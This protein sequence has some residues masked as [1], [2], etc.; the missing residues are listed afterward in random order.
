MTRKALALTLLLATSAGAN[1]PVARGFQAPSDAPAMSHSRAATPS[2]AASSRTATAVAA[3]AAPVLDGRDDDAVWATAPVTTGFRQFQ[4]VE[5]GEARFRTEFRVT[6]DD[7][8]LYVFVRMFDPHPDSIMHALSRRDVRGPSD[9]IK[10]II[11]AYHDRRS[12]VE[13]AVNPDGVKR[14]YAIFDDNH[15]DDSWNGVWDVATRVDSLG[16][17]AEFRVPF[18]QLRYAAAPTQTF[19]FGVWRDI[20]RLNERDS[21]PVYS[22]THTGLA[23]QLGELGGIGDIGSARHVEIAPYVV[24]K[25]ASRLGGSGYERVQDQTVGADLRFGITPNLALNATVNP[26][27]GQV[28]ADPAVVNLGAFETFYSEKRP[29]FV[30]G[31]GLYRFELNCYIA[32]DCGNEGL[33]YSRRIGR[34]PHLLDT[35]GDAGSP[36]GTPIAA[37]AKLTGRSSSGL[38]VGV[39]DAVTQGV[40]GTGGRTIEPRT[41]YAVVRLRQDFRN[42]ESSIGLIG[43]AV[44]R[45]LDT[46]TEDFLRRDAYVAGA[47][48]R[49]RFGGGNYQVSAA[50]VGSRVSGSE[51]AIAATQTDNV[52]GYQRPD[53][54]GR[55]DPARTSLTGSSAELIFG[56][57]GGGLLRFETA[58][59]RQSVGFEPNDLGYL[60]RADQQDWNTWAALSFRQPKGIYKSL[61]INGN[62]WNAWTSDGLPLQRGVNVNAHMWLVNNWWVHAGTSVNRIGGTFCDRCSRGGPAVRQSVSV[63]PWFGVNGDGRRTVSPFL[64][65]NLDR[66]DGGRSSYASFEP[67]FDLRVSTQL[68]ASVGASV[69][70]NVDD[71]QWYGNFADDAGQT[72][73]AFAHLDQKTLGLTTRLSFAATPD[74]ALDFYAQPYTSTGR[75]TSV[76]ELSATPRATLYDARFSSWTPPAGSSD[77]FDF[78]QLRANAVLRWEYRPGSTVFLVWT[79]A[80]DGYDATAPDRSWGA[81][82][83][84]LFGLHPDNTFL[85]KMTYWFGR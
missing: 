54:P 3:P 79:H 6:Y 80:R 50:L 37:A 75:Y 44:N 9:Q 46:W 40:D 26:D 17:T 42:G 20:E 34:S 76:R 22:P 53:G 72:H 31:T 14:D 84:D 73:Y 59:E 12:G 48:V 4:P 67:G 71:S 45:S 15:E 35:Y 66:S 56:K 43:T 65:I 18:S 61:Q 68:Q 24:A 58:L 1:P 29:F 13:L 39:L 83:G 77:G 32:H 25:N 5:D 16:W 81:E 8:A 23:S 57:Y 33:F 47:Q 27:F 63:S 70:H 38:S 51:A 11:D 19:G 55:Y 85:V 82:Y 2:K 36:T 64:W 30:E 41:N 78:R 60:Q 62:Q 10:L 74:L 28:E 21:W 52:H 49:H 69:S 7:R